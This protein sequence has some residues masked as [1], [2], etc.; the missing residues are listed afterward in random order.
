[1]SAYSCKAEDYI[2]VQTKDEFKVFDGKR[3]N[4]DKMDAALVEKRAALLREAFEIEDAARNLDRTLEQISS[5]RSM[6]N[7]LVSGLPSIVRDTCNLK[8]SY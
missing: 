6:L 8:Y 4:A 3:I 5:M 1:M 7:G 2:K